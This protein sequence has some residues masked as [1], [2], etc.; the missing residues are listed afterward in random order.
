LQKVK[1]TGTVELPN[2]LRMQN[3][4]HIPFIK[5]NLIALADLKQ[6]KPEYQWE[7]EEFLLYI[8]DTKTI[9][10][11]ISDRLWPMHFEAI[12]TPKPRT[13]KQNAQELQT[14]TIKALIT[15][16]TTTKTK[17][18]GRALPLKKWH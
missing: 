4:R 12:P 18:K 13:P 11:P 15:T 8:D 3:V 1:E 6:Y 9:R 17:A 10:V 2:G 14:S 5:I 16:A 7:T